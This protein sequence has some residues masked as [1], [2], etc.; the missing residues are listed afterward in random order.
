MITAANGDKAK[1]NGTA[2]VSAAGTPDGV[3][4]YRDQG[5][6]QP[7][8]VR[9]INVLAVVCDGTQASIFGEATVNGS[10]RFNYRIQVTDL[11]QPGRGTDTYGILLSNGYNSGQQILQGG[12]IVIR[13]Q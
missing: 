7:V 8:V 13:R 2:T 6:V 5:P 10:G 11:G 4:T 3:Q 9:S 1:A 12:N